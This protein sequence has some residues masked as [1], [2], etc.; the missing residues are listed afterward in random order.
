MITIKDKAVIAKGQHQLI[1]D[2]GEN[3]P[4]GLYEVEVILNDIKASKK[5]LT[6][7]T[8][9]VNIDPSLTFSREEIYNDEGR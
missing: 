8:S 5:Q 4:E 9:N 7:R 3:V 2:V 6:F 1:I